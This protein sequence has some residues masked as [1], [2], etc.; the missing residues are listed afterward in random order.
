M[1][2]NV[3][4]QNS[5]QNKS[6][7]TDIYPRPWFGVWKYP[8]P[9]SIPFS[10]TL[11]CTDNFLQTFTVSLWTQKDPLR[12]IHI[13]CLRDYDLERSYLSAAILSHGRSRKN[14]DEE[15][16]GSWLWSHSKYQQPIKLFVIEFLNL[17]NQ[18]FKA[19][20]HSVCLHTLLPAKHRFLPKLFLHNIRNS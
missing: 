3:F 1:A 17:N 20:T 10:S 18:A 12:R 15:K 4:H 5:R 14:L 6:S 9:A 11:L 7:L 8:F 13:K 19:N 16:F 2:N